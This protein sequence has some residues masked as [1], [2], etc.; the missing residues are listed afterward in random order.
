MYTYS[1]SDAVAERGSHGRDVRA[2]H[3]PTHYTLHYLH[4]LK[5]WEH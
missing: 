3:S 1:P 5:H 2:G 4:T